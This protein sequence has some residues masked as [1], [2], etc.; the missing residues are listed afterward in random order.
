[1]SAQATI[2]SRRPDAAAAPAAR[3]DAPRPPPREQPEQ[4]E[5]PPRDQPQRPVERPSK[6]E[7]APQ[8]S[9]RRWVRSAL[10]ALL[11]LALIAG[12]YWYVT[13][14]RVMST[15]DAYVEADKV[16][17][18]TDVSGIVKEIDV[19]NNQHVEGGQVLFRLDDLP[20][21][22]ALERAVA[23]VGIV[24]NDLNALKAN[25]GDMQ[26]QIKHANS[27]VSRIS[28]PSSS[29]RSRLSTRHAGICR[30]RNTSSPRSTSNSPRSQPTST[31][32][33]TSRS[34]STR[35]ISRP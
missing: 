19:G 29:R 21:R 9:R 13:G 26:A 31:A 32:T 28:R 25:Y 11:P 1:M 35:A 24:R 6:S 23:Q 5:Q 27:T 7:K 17:I 2:I 15:D 14:G 30:T 16:G 34:S 12:G 33:P 20:F 4:P 22:F 8:I 10:F 3:R 18:S